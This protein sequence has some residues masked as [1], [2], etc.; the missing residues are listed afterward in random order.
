M[1]TVIVE[2]Q[3]ASFG[4]PLEKVFREDRFRFCDLMVV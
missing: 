3:D 4:L 1:E 2:P